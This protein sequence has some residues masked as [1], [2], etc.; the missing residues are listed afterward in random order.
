M[1]LLLDADIEPGFVGECKN[2]IV[3]SATYNV[4]AQR[5]GLDRPGGAE[6]QEPCR[7]RPSPSFCQKPLIKL[8][9]CPYSKAT[10][11]R[12]FKRSLLSWTERLGQYSEASQFLKSVEEW[13]RGIHKDKS[14]T[15]VCCDQPYLRAYFARVS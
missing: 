3:F 10:A 13:M 1:N 2:L 6:T 8:Q 15:L 7:K 14:D 4:V 5:F 9:P 11:R 12:P